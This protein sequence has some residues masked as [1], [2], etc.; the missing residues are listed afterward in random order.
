M[1]AHFVANVHDEWQIEAKEDIAEF[2]ERRN[3]SREMNEEMLMLDE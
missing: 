1:D 2:D 3:T